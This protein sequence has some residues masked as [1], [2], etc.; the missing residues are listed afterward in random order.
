MPGSRVSYTQC[1][2]CVPL[3]VLLLS[4][5]LTWGNVNLVQFDCAYSCAHH[6]CVTNI[7]CACLCCT[8]F[9][10]SKTYSVFFCCKLWSPWRGLILESSGTTAPTL[11][12]VS[13]VTRLP[14]WAVDTLTRR[15]CTS[16]SSILCSESVLHLLKRGWNLDPLDIP[17]AWMFTLQRA[18]VRRSSLT[19]Y[20]Q[21]EV[22]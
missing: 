21:I 10:K 6:N 16:C 7:T 14:P 13:G 4:L 12:T 9:F 22:L 18:S 11:C 19:K 15:H 1:E 5:I 17:V 20:F 2:L 3:S 8:C